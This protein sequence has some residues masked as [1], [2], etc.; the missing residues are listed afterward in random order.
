MLDAKLIAQVARAPMFADLEPSDLDDLVGGMRHLTYAPGEEL[1]HQ[2][3][4]PDGVYVIVGGRVQI[5]TKLPGGGENLIAVLEPGSTVGDL[6]LVGMAR[7]TA[8]V[9]ALDRVEALYTDSQV[10]RAALVQLRPS[11]IKVLRKLAV[12]L[13]ERLRILHGQIRESLS[14]DDPAYAPA[15]MPT[16]SGGATALCAAG[17]SFAYPAFLPLLRCFRGFDPDQ[18]RS[19][20]ELAEVVALPRGAPLLAAGAA[21]GACYFVVRGA[22]AS[23][24]I[25]DKR[26]HQ[27]AVLGPGYLCAIESVIEDRPSSVA[28]VVRETSL[29]LKLSQSAFLDLY[30]G[31]D[32][33]ALNLLHAVNENQAEM[34]SRANNHL[35]RL[36]GLKRLSRQLCV[37]PKS[38]PHARAALI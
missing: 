35:T 30:L 11:A 8:T 1:I 28:F 26:M 6:A 2:G 14:A 38:P 22:I 20:S 33:L 9:R 19:I 37:N 7:R 21:P 5:L 31:N 16:T 25:E 15:I 34:I 18:I 32:R 27:L 23:G 24:I 12:I 29:L 13:S 36:L 10:F 17:A 4:L 3:A